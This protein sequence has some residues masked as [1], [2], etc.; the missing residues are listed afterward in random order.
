MTNDSHLDSSEQV[1]TA[2]DEL[3]EKNLSRPAIPRW[4]SSLV[5]T[6]AVA[7]M[8]YVVQEM[9]ENSPA[10]DP[11]VAVM[12]PVGDELSSGQTGI[13]APDVEKPIRMGDLVGTWIL[14]DG[15]RRVITMQSDGTA[16]MKV[17]F[18]FL[19]ALRYGSE[20]ILELNWSLE[21]NI[22]KQTIVD[23]K[24][25]A[26][27]KTLVS[28][29]GSSAAYRVLKMEQGK[30]YL[31]ELGKQPDSYTWSRSEDESL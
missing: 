29:F 27:R 10:T 20:L 3:V 11:D 21:E 4:L 24:P 6:L 15:I 2:S 22:L 28:D 17:N 5:V 31:E 14:D 12:T 1:S 18:D 13:V 9:K 23:G 25:E 16:R 19:T 8:I 30:L 26:G 7:G